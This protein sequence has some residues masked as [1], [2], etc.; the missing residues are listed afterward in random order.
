MLAEIRI[1]DPDRP[2]AKPYILSHNTVVEEEFGESIVKRYK[3]SFEYVTLESPDRK[4]GKFEQWLRE[5]CLR[6]Q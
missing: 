6:K 4:E 3:Y 5:E 2:K 1:I